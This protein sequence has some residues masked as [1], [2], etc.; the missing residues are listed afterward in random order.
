MIRDS[1]VSGLKLHNK[2]LLNNWSELWD[3]PYKNIWCKAELTSVH[4][5]KAQGLIDSWENW[6]SDDVEKLFEIL[7]NYTEI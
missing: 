4:H 1:G 5:E 3:D 7:F 2:Y 6:I